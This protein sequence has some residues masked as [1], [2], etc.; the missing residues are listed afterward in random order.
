M[1]ASV[2][3][4]AAA[5]LGSARWPVSGW[6]CV[7]FASCPAAATAGSRLGRPHHLVL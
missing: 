3:L 4:A 2:R 5:A 6:P 1:V 7:V